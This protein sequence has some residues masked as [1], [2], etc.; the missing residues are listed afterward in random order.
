MHYLYLHVPLLTA[1]QMLKR[2]ELRIIRRFIRTYILMQVIA[3]LLV[4]PS[5]YAEHF[6]VIILGD[7]DMAFPNEL[8]YE[9]TGGP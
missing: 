9:V 5:R 7:G 8:L 2:E 6:D 4:P 3:T 1:I